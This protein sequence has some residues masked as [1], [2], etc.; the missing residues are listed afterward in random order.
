[1]YR[2]ASAEQIREAVESL[3][4]L[5]SGEC[6]GNQMDFV[7]DIALAIE[8]LEKH[9]PKKPEGRHTDYKCPVCGR[10]VRSGK[11]SSSLIRD[12]RCQRCGQVLDWQ[13]GNR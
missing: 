12:N 6:T 11:G 5:I 1:M 7:P 10:R 4:Y 3:S 13:E 2:I 9:I 8:A